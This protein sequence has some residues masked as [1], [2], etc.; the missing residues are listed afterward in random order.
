MPLMSLHFLHLFQLYNH[1]VLPGYHF[2]DDAILLYDAIHKYVVKYVDLYY[3]RS[4][5]L[6]YFKS[7]NIWGLSPLNLGNI[8]LA[9]VLYS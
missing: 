9:N 4:K 2:R 6:D 7:F 5:F 3:G 1:K 8:T